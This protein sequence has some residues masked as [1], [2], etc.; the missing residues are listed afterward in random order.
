[1]ARHVNPRDPACHFFSS[2]TDQT[3]SK[4]EELGPSYWV[5]NLVSPVRFSTAMS[6]A[7]HALKSSKIFIEIGP[8]SALAGPI[9]QIL[10][11]ESSCDDE[12]INVLTRGKDSHEEVLKAAGQLWLKN[13]P[14]AL[15][16]LTGGGQFLTDLPLYPWYYEEPLWHE[17][18]LSREYRLREFP[19]HEL[20][21]SRISES[22]NANPAWRNVLRLE[23]VPWIADH[24]IEGNIILPGVSY[25]YM[26]GEAIRQVSGRDDFTCREVHIKAAMLLYEDG[27]TEIIT[28]LNRVSLTDSV[29]SEWYDFSVSSYQAG[30]WIRHAFGRARSGGSA[31]ESPVLDRNTK[32]Y[33]RVCSSKSWYRKFRSLGLEYGPRFTVLKNITTD[34]VKPRLAASLAL[35]MRPEDE[36]YYSIHPG[37]L[38]GL[39]QALYP[40]ASCGQTRRFSQ[41]ALIT[42]VDE[43]YMRSLPKGSKELQCHVEITEERR[44]SFLGNVSAVSSDDSRENIV[45]SQ[46]WQ[47]ARL[48]TSEETNA[49]QNPHG[50]AELEWRE[51]ID[52]MKA[53]SLIKPAGNKSD[54]YRLL[55]RFNVLCMAQSVDRLR[56]GPR[57]TR[58]YLS[59]FHNWLK[60]TVNGLATGASTCHGVPDAADLVAME[61]KERS[62][63]IDD[64]YNKLRGSPV[65]APATAVHRISSHCGSIFSGNTSELELLLADGVLPR[66]YD[67]LLE[68]TDSSA[69]IS[70]VAHKKPNLRV[71]EIGAGTGGATNTTLKALSSARGERMYASYT[72][73][74]VSPG[75]FPDAK[76]RFKDY[77]GIKFAV[78]DITK[79]PLEQGFEADSFDLIVAWNVMHATPSLHQSLSNVKKLIHPQ[80][81]F[82]LQEVDP[83]TKW[84]DHAFGVIS[85]W[86]AGINDG[87]SSQPHVGLHR[88]EEELTLAGFAN[89]SAMY[90]G[91][92]CNNIVC[93]PCP[94]TLP[95][96]RMT[97]LHHARQEVNKICEDLHAA[98]YQVDGY[99]LEDETAQLPRGQDVV[100]VLDFA[101]PFF[102][103]TNQQNFNHFQRFVKAADEGA[104]G[105]LWLTSLCQIGCARPEYSPVL[106]FARVL[107]TEVNLDFGV[108]ELETFEAA[109]DAIAKVL[110]QFQHRE[111]DKSNVN[112]EY[113]WVHIGGKTLIS[114]YHYTNIA[115]ETTEIPT[116]LTVKKLEQH[117]PGLTDTLYWRSIP[118]RAL[119][120]H[121]VR[122]EVK[123]VGMNYKVGLS[124][125]SLFVALSDFID[126]SNLL[127]TCSSR[128]ESSLTQLPLMRDSAWSAPASSR[129]LGQALGG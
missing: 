98:G 103:N 84:I 58:E 110:S 87:R 57:P 51:D 124:S 92:I 80:G 97:L 7:L 83:L 10:T 27:E 47:M 39:V 86:W 28:Q 74:D 43:F 20:L 117:K 14:V 24:E 12:Y 95:W 78:L 5:Q 89:V 118:A 126:P 127:R 17:S 36:R 100:S 99:A 29:D 32:P 67:C 3:V 119:G 25:L 93:Q 26:A 66:V 15:N 9:R 45:L 18:R 113:E 30:S 41:P 54:W 35:D 65:G 88:W 96:R 81:R 52:L 69:F 60:D 68:D 11:A 104:C 76:E 37:T 79:D 120:D 70:L 1:M 105:V 129:R 111:C 13:Y 73:T 121:E 2:V 63:M 85:G 31:S 22:T 122:I 102:Y 77:S 48:L 75:F 46:G 64:L 19:H 59:N 42:Y 91:Y 55:D 108:L 107:R 128:K 106:G 94:S 23:D 112:P 72:Y 90:D 40:A 62:E 49:D 34:P 101:A 50:T 16:R 44:T 71:L 82:L 61:V 123:A 56:Y 33:A 125:I 21:G 115:R 8:H 4:G 116:N 53:S 6:Q 109:P 38:D 114:R